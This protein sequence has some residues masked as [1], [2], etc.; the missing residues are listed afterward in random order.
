MDK[1]TEIH[2][3]LSGALVLISGFALFFGWPAWV[4]GVVV[5]LVNLYL[6]AILFEVVHRMVKKSETK[7]GVLQTNW[8][9]GAKKLKTHSVTCS[10]N[11]S[12]KKVAHSKGIM[13]N[14]LM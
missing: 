8:N 6:F 5:I 1:A 10:Q 14:L 2:F 13:A 11:I 7:E 3:L 4:S 12:H 9:V